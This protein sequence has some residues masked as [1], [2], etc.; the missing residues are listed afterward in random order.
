ML[1][2]LRTS[3]SPTAGVLFLGKAEMLLTHGDAVRARSTSSAGCSPRSRTPAAPAAC[4]S[5]CGPRGARRRPA[6]TSASRRPPSTAASGRADRRSTPRGALA[7]RQRQRARELFGIA[8][9]DVG[10][11]VAGPRDL[12]PPRRAARA[13]ST[14]RSAERRAGRASAT[15]PARAADEARC[16]YDVQVVPLLDERR[17]RRSAPASPSPTSPRYRELARGARAR[18]PRPRDRLRGAADRQRG[19]RDHQRGAAVDGRGARDHQRGAP[20]HQRGARDDERGA[21]ATNEEL[22]TTNEELRE[23]TGEVDEVNAFLEASSSSLRGGVVVVDRDLGCGSGTGAR[24]SCGGCAPTRSQGRAL[25]ALDIGLPGGGS[26]AAARRRPVGTARATATCGVRGA[27]D[28]FGRDIACLDRVQRAR[29]GRGGA[30]GRDRAHGRAR[31]EAV[32][33]NA[34]DET[35]SS[36]QTPCRRLAA[37]SRLDAL[38]RRQHLQQAQPRLVESSSRRP[39]RRTGG[40]GSLVRDA[41]PQDR[42]AQ[43]K[44][45]KSTACR[46]GPRRW[47]PAR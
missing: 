15:S 23:R 44:I 3:R 47:S 39:R 5:P 2:R 46:R 20:V 30:D 6:L 18:Q 33:R 10:R 31:T 1:Q 37:A 14:R 25:T 45:R 32:V 12:L 41:Q 4:A 17:R 21:P 29:D 36:H 9:P 40:R 38:A 16:V 35:A 24:S 26:C 27:R 42:S 8:A 13:R 43:G 34:R 22:Q 7:L 11:P 28:R 19:A